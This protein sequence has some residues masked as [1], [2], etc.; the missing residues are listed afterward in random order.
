MQK[1]YA[2]QNNKIVKAGP[3]PKSLVYF[4]VKKKR[5]ILL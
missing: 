2:E 5:G 3:G 4:S 1:S